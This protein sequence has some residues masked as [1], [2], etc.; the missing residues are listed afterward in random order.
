MNKSTKKLL[1][2]VALVGYVWATSAGQLP[3][4]AVTL[5]VMYV[6][7]VLI[8]SKPNNKPRFQE[9]M[10]DRINSMVGVTPG[11]TQNSPTLP[12]KNA[13]TNN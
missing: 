3:V 4:A 7:W 8:P 1:T 11:A 12:V 9:K 10:L 13:G 2:L 5:G 6:L